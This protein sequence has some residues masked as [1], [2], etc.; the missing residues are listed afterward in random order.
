MRKN[1][2]TETHSECPAFVVRVVLAVFVSLALALAVAGC[3]KE[4]EQAKPEKKD[5]AGK[6]DKKE[7]DKDKQSEAPAVEE[8]K[9]VA[10]QAEPAAE[11]APTADEVAREEKLAGAAEAILQDGLTAEMV[12][13]DDLARGAVVI[14]DEELNAEILAVP[15]VVKKSGGLEAGPAGSAEEVMDDALVAEMIVDDDRKGAAERI[16]EEEL[17]DEMATEGLAP[18]PEEDAAEAAPAGDAGASVT[19]LC[20]VEKIKSIVQGALAEPLLACYEDAEDT[21]GKADGALRTRFT[22]GVEG[23]V[24]DV[25]ILEDT[26]GSQYLVDCVTTVLSE[27]KYPAPKEGVCVVEMPFVFQPGEQAEPEK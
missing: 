3:S 23:V 24:S 12:R 7:A 2:L 1:Q 8:E 9:T 19:G 25:K 20:D 5:K 13:D 16:L 10:D 21:D 26:A 17:D 22:I 15:E 27:T 18:K 11:T 4:Q 14:M 6:S